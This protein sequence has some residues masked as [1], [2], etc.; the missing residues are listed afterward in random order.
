MLVSPLYVRA[1]RSVAFKLIALVA[2]TALLTVSSKV[3]VPMLPVPMTLQTLAV[4]L[5]GALY[6]WRLGSLAVIAWLVE[7]GL[8]L[9]VFAGAAA[10]LPYLFG[11]TGGYLL[12]FPLVAMVVGLLC[13]RGWGG[14]QV[15]WAFGAMLIG[16]ALCLAI[17]AT[18]LAFF[19]GAER[20]F[21]LGVAPFVLG[22]LSKSVLGA[23]L[24]K[25]STIEKPL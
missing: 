4:T 21:S 3:Q 25:A 9:P 17:G 22:G 6:G 16:N 15:V 11:P 18:W 14:K 12:S 23:A 1:D 10:G 24:L 20:A 2:A 19:T 7:G 5:I 13:E 8:G